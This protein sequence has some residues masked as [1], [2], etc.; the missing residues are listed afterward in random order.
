M[1]R[2]WLGSKRGGIA[3]TA[4][5]DRNRFRPRLEGFEERWVPDGGSGVGP[6]DYLTVITVDFTRMG[7]AQPPSQ[8][9][10]AA[11]TI[12]LTVYTTTETYTKTLSF[13]GGTSVAGVASTFAQAL[14]N[15]GIGSATANGGVLT[16]NWVTS[17]FC[18]VD[19]THTN[20]FNGDPVVFHNP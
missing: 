9:L 11:D 8:G 4:T 10:I 17:S 15:D 7:V 13:L 5:V 6:P 2:W 3:R 18:S 1:A 12:T 14:R 19:V 16:F 20:T